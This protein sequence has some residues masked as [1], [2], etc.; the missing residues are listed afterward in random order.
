MNKSTIVKLI[1]I[2]FGLSLFG[3]LAIYCASSYNGQVNYSDSFYFVKKQF[4]GLILGTIVFIIACKFDYHKFDK[5]KWY[6]IGI[7]II[8]L[9]LVFV[10]GISIS[11]NGARRWIGFGSFSIQS[12]EVAKFGFVIFASCY[13]AKYFDSKNKLK[14][15][16]PVIFFGGLICSLVLLEPNLSVTLCIGMV[17]L[18][19]LWVGGINYKA[20]L[21]IL[22]PALILLPILI[23]A[24]PY[25][26]QRLMAFINPWANPMEEGFQLIQSLY[27]LGAGG[28]FGVGIFNS[29]QKYL[30]LPFSESDF[31]FSIIGEEFGFLGCVIL[32]IVY[33][34]LIIQGIK[35]ALNSLDRCGSYM[36]FG[37]TMIIAMQLI[38]NL[39]VVTGLIPP[40]GIPLPF[41]SAGG[42][43][44]VVFFGGIG[45]LVNI[46]TSSLKS[47]NYLSTKAFKM[48]DFRNK[49]KKVK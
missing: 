34:T 12:S 44:L 16:L 32:I 41:I 43:S 37:I 7:S 3:L 27:S 14:L 49:R 6:I 42:S 26:I 9:I 45:V 33:A 15:Y 20:F 2:S 4:I 36:A 24:E 22:I 13:M 25:R 31:I 23:I 30:F 8:M 19:L 1:I 17:L 48:I 46:A 18:L 38:I 29:R 10:P 40:T 11:A 39:C 47:K 28:L 5:I 35:I 21:F